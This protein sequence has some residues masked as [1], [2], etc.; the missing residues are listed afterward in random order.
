MNGTM[1][2]YYSLFVAVLIGFLLGIDRERLVAKPYAGVRTFVLISL[3]GYLS[4][5]VYSLG[6]DLFIL[7]AG[8]FTSGLILLAYFFVARNGHTGITTE[9]LIFL[10]FVLGFLAGFDYTVDL[11]LVVAIVVLLVIS[12][13]DVIHNTVK[14][15]IT[16]DEW[17]S[18]VKF[19]A[20]VIGVLVVLPKTVE[21]EFLEGIEFMEP[22]YVIEVG[23]VGWLVL[24]I[25]GINF[26]TYFLTKIYGPKSA[27]LIAAMAGLVSSTAVTVSSSGNYKQ[28]A[29]IRELKNILV[30]NATSTLKASAL[31]VTILYDGTF[32][33]PLFLLILSA[34]LAIASHLVKRPETSETENMEEIKTKEPFSFSQITKFALFFIVLLPSLKLLSQ[35]PSGLIVGSFFGGSF[36]IDGVLITLAAISSDHVWLAVIATVL[37]GFTTKSVVSFVSSGSIQFGIKVSGAFTLCS[38]GAGLIAFLVVQLFGL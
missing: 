12:F 2:D 36:D 26:V 22:L 4:S 38:I 16:A 11:S 18:A 9:F 14:N 37:G 7:T 10:V 32:F 3:L 6:L 23:T 33:T 29:N 21:L 5:V 25:A 31:T 17:V 28:S 27:Y 24:L 20:L 30:A 8:M 34:A 15:A 19:T 1:I 35:L 13:K